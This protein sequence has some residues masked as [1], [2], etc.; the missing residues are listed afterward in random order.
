MSGTL[1]T[2]GTPPPLPA[3]SRRTSRAPGDP[4]AELRRL[5]GDAVDIRTPADVNTPAGT[6]GDGRPVVVVDLGWDADLSALPPADTLVLPVHG[7]RGRAVVGPV[8]R[9]GLPGCPHCLALRVRA[10]DG[11]RGVPVGAAPGLLPLSARPVDWLP[12]G[13]VRL[14][15]AVLRAEADRIAAGEPPRATEAAF[16]IGPGRLGGDWHP[17]L[18]HT[19][20]TS[21]Q[22][23]AAR[24]PLPPPLP[25][26]TRPLPA[27]GPESARRHPATRYADQLE[28]EYLD[29][30]SG[31][32]GSASVGDGAALP[33]TQVSV[34]TLW[35]FDEIAIGRAGDYA[36]ARPAAVLEGLERYAGWHCGGRD[37]VRFASYAE[38]TGHEGADS[39]ADPRALFL[40][41]DED[42]ARPDFDYVP[43][44]PDT[45]TGWA[46]AHSALTGRPVLLPFHVAYYGAARRPETGPR[47]V[48]EN[49][50]GC[51]LGSGTEEALIAA[52]L[53]V[54]ERDAFLCTWYSGTPLPEL[55]LAS[56][57]G[58]PDGL[59][60]LSGPAA[61]A[62][63]TVRHRTGR[64]LRAFRAV[65]AFDI[66]V[67]LLLS[68]S[69]EPGH[70]ATLVTAGSGLTTDAALLGAVHE[71][72]AVAP[73]ITQEF[74]RNRP[75]LERALDDPDLVRRMEDH[76]LVGALPRARPWFSF[77]LDGMP[78]DLASAPAVHRPAGDIAADLGA[79][80]AAA[81]RDGQ[82]VIVVD[83]TTSE[84]HRLGLSCVKAV[85]PGT[86][87]MTFGHRHRRLPDPGVLQ[88]FRARNGLDDRVFS[89]EEV[90]HEPHPFP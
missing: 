23:T 53:E 37:P 72:S 5:V 38:L 88:A 85:V 30:W 67:V 7:L 33:S 58:G 61:R 40:H 13:A 52:L 18:P 78:P 25:D 51:A 8:L 68:V 16:A 43:Y 86:V 17:A 6:P 24:R 41:R 19:L 87:P 54:A 60:G 31:I 28:R 47:F 45:P 21:P 69:D 75:E 35:G 83:H 1:L 73:V 82:E 84:L 89:P 9:P 46:R 36:N 42:Y 49:S 70:P 22:C 39:A 10:A 29:A 20:C 32:C 34:P 55:D 71:M 65:G 56:R 27:S 4:V 2:P 26:L 90:R 3:P 50:N 80:L 79:M 62:V 44:S 74:R 77:L 15:A 48:Y 12:P 64:E 81:R 76:S 66:P 14:V 59:S 11:P 63:H 57:P